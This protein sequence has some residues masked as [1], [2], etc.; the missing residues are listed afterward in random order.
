MSIVHLRHIKQSLE[1][2]YRSI[3]DM[4]DYKSKPKEQEEDAFLSRAQAAFSIVI[5]AKATPA[6]AASSIVD[7]FDDNGVDAIYF[8]QD[9]KLLYLVQSKCTRTVRDQL[10]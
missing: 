8:D 1:T 9:E 7:S 3:I 5:A 6:A 4:S 2:D 10:I